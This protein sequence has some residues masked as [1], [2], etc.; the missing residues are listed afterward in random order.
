WDEP[1]QG[2]R[3]E[4][5]DEHGDGPPIGGGEA[6]DPPQHGA[7]ELGPGHR[8]RVRPD[9][10]VRTAPSHAP[11]RTAASRQPLRRRVRPASSR[12]RAGADGSAATAA[13]VLATPPGPV[14]S[15][16]RA[17]DSNPRW[18]EDHNG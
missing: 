1:E 10:A 18:P 2:G 15:E 8:G 7:I 9:Q 11:E 4:H 6:P 12:R 17:L 16:R 14:T 3:G 13:V 5:R